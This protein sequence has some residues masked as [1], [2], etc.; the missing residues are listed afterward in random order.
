[1]RRMRSDR[2]LICV[3]NL[4]VPLDRRVWLECQAL[5]ASGHGVSVVCPR[6][7]GDARYEEL[8]GVRI[9]KYRPPRPATGVISYAWEFF[10]CLV[11][12][13]L[14]SVKAFARSC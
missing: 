14:L 5:V 3:Q 2:V 8:D 13:F 12:T 7:P 6:G 1:M 11:M 10:Y 4:P 9:Y